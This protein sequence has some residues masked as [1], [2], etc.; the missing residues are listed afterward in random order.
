MTTIK[1]ADL[2]KITGRTV[3]NIRHMQAHKYTPWDD[4][5]FPPGKHRRY[6]GFHALTMILAEKLAEGGFTAASAAEFVNMQRRAI[7]KFLDM[8]EQGAV[9]EPLHVAAISE[10]RE[11]SMIGERWVPTLFWGTGTTEQLSDVFSSIIE[12]AGTV[13]KTRQGKT[14]ERCTG[15]LKVASVPLAEAY[16]ILKDRAEAA[17]Y[18]VDG[19]K[20]HKI[21]EGDTEEGAE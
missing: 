7:D 6:T 15:I 20:V 9:G 17:G 16:R 5:E 12:R 8:I 4:T 13:H 3:D 11:D 21:A 14:T 1:Q 18:V 2:C 19:R 10:L